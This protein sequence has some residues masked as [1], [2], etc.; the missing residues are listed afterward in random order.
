MTSLADLIAA[1][2]EVSDAEIADLANALVVETPTDTMWIT[3]E[4]LMARLVVKFGADGPE[5]A[6][7]LFGTLRAASAQS[8]IID[9]AYRRLVNS[10]RGLNLADPATAMILSTLITPEG[11]RDVDMTRLLS[12]VEPTRIAWT[13][14]NL[15]VPYVTDQDVFAARGNL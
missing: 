14:V 8:A 2:P 12:L 3:P 7:R 1:N 9:V 5:I 11:F 15:G 4:Q 13:Q 6:E 10:D